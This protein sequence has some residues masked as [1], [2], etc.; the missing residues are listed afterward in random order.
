[1][2]KTLYILFAIVGIFVVGNSFRMPP[3][4]DT[5]E[6]L[7]KKLFFETAL[8]KDSSISC[9]SCHIPQFAF[10]DT[11]AFS[12]GVNNK[13][14]L[15]NTPSV[16]NMSAR[17]SFFYD[18]RATTLEDQVHFPIEDKN[19]MNVLLEEV[20]KRLN[21][22]ATYRKLFKKIY[23]SSATK[24]TV[25]S[26]IAAYERTLESPGTSFDKYQRGDTSAISASAKRGHKLFVSDRAK[27]FEC[28]F[29]PDFTADE[30]KNIG[31]YDGITYTDVGR[32]SVTKDSND[33]GKFKVPGLRNVAVTAPYMH[34]GMFKTLAEVIEYYSNPYQFIAKPLFVDSLVKQ[35]IHF[36][37]QEKQD[38]LHFLE[39][40]TDA[41]FR[42]K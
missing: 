29:S 14:G 8:S 31:L 35:P 19:E 32:F 7:G 30:F 3:I 25:T 9:A 38:L 40:L 12:K 5:E 24:A 23:K 15:R 27:C 36:T 33:I 11:V 2:K 20:V 4:I 37:A 21:S 6:A 39:S 34:N 42:R 16:M 22:D 41:E 17:S 10:A 28:H 13:L 26:A 18:G 1:M